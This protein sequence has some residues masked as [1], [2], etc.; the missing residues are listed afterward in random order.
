MIMLLFVSTST[1]MRIFYRRIV[2]FPVSLLYAAYILVFR[3]ITR[4]ELEQALRDFGMNDER[5]IKE[6]ISEVD[7]DNVSK[8]HKLYSKLII[9]MFVRSRGCR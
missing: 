5:N 1:I 3:Y 7:S 8:K 6:I 4:E 2:P 9:K